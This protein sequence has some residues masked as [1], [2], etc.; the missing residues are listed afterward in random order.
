MKNAEWIED[1]GYKIIDDQGDIVYWEQ[2]QLDK[3]RDFK[4]E[5]AVSDITE[6]IQKRD[7]QGAVDVIRKKVQERTGSDIDKVD[8]K[9]ITRE[10]KAFI[11]HNP[12]YAADKA[13]LIAYFKLFK[14]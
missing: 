6:I 2:D 5:R 3:H 1:Q 12:D 11:K 8:I 7:L 10:I 4:K 9:L 14:L 13:N